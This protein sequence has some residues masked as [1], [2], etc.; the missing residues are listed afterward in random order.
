MDGGKWLCDPAVM[1]RRGLQRDNRPLLLVSATRDQKLPFLGL[2]PRFH[3]ADYGAFS[4]RS[5]T[6]IAVAAGV[7]RGSTGGAAAAA[8]GGGGGGGSLP[9]VLSRL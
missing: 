9:G 3:G 2:L 1:R 5:M 4:C 8:A 7:G 6:R